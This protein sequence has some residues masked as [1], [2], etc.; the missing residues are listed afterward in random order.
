MSFQVNVDVQLSAANG[1]EL[2]A[3]APLP[4]AADEAGL[5]GWVG[6]GGRRNGKDQQ[7]NQSDTTTGKIV[8]F[9]RHLRSERDIFV[10]C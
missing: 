6:A 5:I 1:A 7:G 9:H 4:A 8:A 10:P 3:V 2:F